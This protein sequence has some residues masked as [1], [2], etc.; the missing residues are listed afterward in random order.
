MAW[1]ALPGFLLKDFW[2]PFHKTH[3]IKNVAV[4]AKACEQ[5]CAATK[6]CC[7]WGV[8]AVTHWEDAVDADQGLEELGWEIHGGDDLAKFAKAVWCTTEACLDPN[9]EKL[10]VNVGLLKDV[11]SV[12]VTHKGKEVGRFNI[13]KFPPKEAGS[14]FFALVTVT[15]KGWKFFDK[16][17]NE[18]GS[19]EQADALKNLKEDPENTHNEV[20]FV[21]S[22]SCGLF[23]KEGKAAKIRLEAL[24]SGLLKKCDG[25]HHES[26]VDG[27][28][29]FGAAVAK[30]AKA[31]RWSVDASSGSHGISFVSLVCAVFSSVALVFVV[32]FVAKK[33]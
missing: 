14:K 10:E 2:F 25:H 9:A 3:V 27:D 6:D 33:N 11:W 18:I 5:T 8:A 32:V 30:A 15:D 21:R 23:K 12:I 1:K 7:R 17:G 29:A 19:V 4:P 13:D 16:D 31:G 22:Y 28:K 20:T 24:Q 26:V